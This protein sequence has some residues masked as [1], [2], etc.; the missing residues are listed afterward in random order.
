MAKTEEK[1]RIAIRVPI[2][3]QETVQRAA[4]IMG[5]PVNAYIVQ[6]VHQHAL[7]AI[8]RYDMKNITLSESDSEWFLQQLTQLQQPHSKLKRALVNYHRRLHDPTTDYSPLFQA[9]PE[10]PT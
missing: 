8:D 7:D 10:N 3:I 1:G 4:E 6:V 2:D 9:P 5:T